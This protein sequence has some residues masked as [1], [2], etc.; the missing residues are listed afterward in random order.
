MVATVLG[1]AGLLPFGFGA[2]VEWDRANYLKQKEKE[3]ENHQAL[4]IWYPNILRAYG[5]TILSFMG[6]VHW[7]LEMAHYGGSSFRIVRYP[8]VFDFDLARI[9][10]LVPT[11]RQR[12][13]LF[14][15]NRDPVAS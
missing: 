8:V 12:R 10:A 4:R 9:T 2:Y 5:A 15:G 3:A 1:A 13:A 14:M 7:G 11:Y 6:A